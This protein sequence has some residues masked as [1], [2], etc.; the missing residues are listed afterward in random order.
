M[1]QSCPCPPGVFNNHEIELTTLR[2]LCKD[3]HKVCKSIN[4]VK[5][6]KSGH[7]DIFA[8][9]KELLLIPDLQL[10]DTVQRLSEAARLLSRLGEVEEEFDF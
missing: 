2:W 1:L 3:F 7:D 4:I 8:K 6:I 5:I 9:M 10:K